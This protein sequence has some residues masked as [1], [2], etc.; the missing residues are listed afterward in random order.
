[1]PIIKF[2]F[3]MATKISNCLKRYFVIS[4]VALAAIIAALV[5]LFVHN[6]MTKEATRSTSL[7]TN[8]DESIVTLS[9]SALRLTHSPTDLPTSFPTDAPSFSPTT[10]EPT[11][12]PTMTPTTTPTT[13][14]PTVY[15]TWEPTAYETEYPTEFEP[16]GGPVTVGGGVTVSSDDIFR[17]KMHW[18]SH[19]FWQEEERERFWCIECTRCET[20]NFSDDGEGCEQVWDC[21]ADDQLWLQPCRK[22]YGHN[23]F[24]TEHGDYHQIH[25]ENTNLCWE[26]TRKRYITIQECD[27]SQLSQLW[28]KVTDNAFELIPANT[29]DEQFC[30]T[31]QHHPKPSEIVGLKECD[32]AHKWDTGY[33][34]TYPAL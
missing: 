33:W 6:E 17:L 12:E 27:A 32:L 3:K 10:E 4:A 14:T 16:T 29:G 2:D 34:I 21:A 30:V 11:I 23:F 19:F 26:R 24:V 18:E 15:P 28:T 5:G 22:G 9:P 8:E 7:Q 13:M 1:M 25:I 31:Q 20:L